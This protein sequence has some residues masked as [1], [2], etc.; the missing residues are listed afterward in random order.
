MGLRC[1]LLGLACWP[2]AAL[3]YFYIA[4][5][6]LRIPA[7]YASEA[8]FDATTRARAGPGAQWSS[9]SLVARRVDQA[10]LSSA[11]HAIIQGD[12]HWTNADGVVEFETSAIFGV[13]RHT[14]RNLP[15]YGDM[16]RNGPFLFP[17][18]TERN[19]YDYWDTHF[20]GS[21]RA[22]Y[23]RTQEIDGVP[24]RV[25]RFRAA[26]L[27]ETAGYSQLPDV[28]E[29]FRVH[30]D[31]SGTLWIEPTSGV[32]VDY[33]EQGVSYFVE[34]AGGKRV[35]DVYIWKD[36]YTP[37]TRLAKM[38]LAVAE[39]R[40]IVLLETAI[41]AALLLAGAGALLLGLRPRRAGRARANATLGAAPDPGAPA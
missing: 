30:S 15:G 17:L 32:V 20:I 19:S 37:R 28:P 8:S 27:D 34:P 39:R 12:L 21:C 16:A 31:A 1:A 10:L 5:Q 24:V 6:L 11:G 29:R 14:R 4:P 18:H 40:R 7:A 2:L 33:E 38:Q 22:T 36:R 13:D 9:S 41:P 3:H 23:E 26:G 35:A 25:Y